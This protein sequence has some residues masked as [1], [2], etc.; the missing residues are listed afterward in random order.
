MPQLHRSNQ[1]SRL[2][3]TSGSFG[4]IAI[5]ALPDAIVIDATTKN[6]DTAGHCHRDRAT[7]SLPIADAVRLRDALDAA[8]AHTASA[9]IASRQTQLWSEASYF[10]AALAS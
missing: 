4:E 8:I 5:M 7:A 9:D 2:L 1:S 3:S 10:N 6:Y